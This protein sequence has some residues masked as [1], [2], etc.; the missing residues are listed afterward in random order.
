M[1]R[2]KHE[3]QKNVPTGS[4]K[5]GGHSYKLSALPELMKMYQIWGR[6]NHILKEIDV[7]AGCSLTELLATVIHESM[8]AFKAQRA[9]E[10]EH[11]IMINLDDA[12]TQLLVDN[13]DFFVRAL[14]ELKKEKG[15]NDS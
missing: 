10:L 15:S 11:Y 6:C 2:K 1:T 13:A 8:E 14:T 7:D 4:L 5:I 9:L 12:F 3:E